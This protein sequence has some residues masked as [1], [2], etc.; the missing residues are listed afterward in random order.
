M[1]IGGLD[2]DCSSLVCTLH[3][4]FKALDDIKSHTRGG[5]SLSLV[6]LKRSMVQCITCSYTLN[7][8]S[9]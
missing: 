2:R 4:F 8:V 7:C 5:S 9:L 1:W 6:G 3:S